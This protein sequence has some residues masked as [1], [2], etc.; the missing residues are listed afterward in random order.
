MTSSVN[1]SYPLLNVNV[2]MSFIASCT[3][4]VVELYNGVGT[5][6]GLVRYCVNGTWSHLCGDINSKV[7]NNLASVICSELGYSPYG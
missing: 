1:V 4:G 2:F 5:I 3:D 6:Y 7:D